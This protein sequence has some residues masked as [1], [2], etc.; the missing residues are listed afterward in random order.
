[1]G[2]SADSVAPRPDT[3]ADMRPVRSG[4]QRGASFAEEDALARRQGVLF[5]CA[6]R[7]LP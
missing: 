2:F 3:P 7:G 4:P 5:L 1:M 6:R